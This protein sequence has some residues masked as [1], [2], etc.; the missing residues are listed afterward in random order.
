MPRHPLTPD[1]REALAAQLTRRGEIAV[2]AAIGTA[3]ATLRRARRGARLNP[4]TAHAI[5]D[6]LTAEAHGA[7]EQ[8]AA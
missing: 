8:F 6:Y 5:T 4:T 7:L 3:P 1:T 2:C